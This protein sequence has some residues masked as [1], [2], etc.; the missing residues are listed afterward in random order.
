MALLVVEEAP[1][2]QRNLEVEVEVLE[3]SAST[4]QLL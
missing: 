2:G 4:V 1:L 3:L